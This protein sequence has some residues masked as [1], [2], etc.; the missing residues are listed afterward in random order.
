MNLTD[1]IDQHWR[2]NPLQKIAL[3]RLK[4]KTLRD[5]LFYLPSRYAQAGQFKKISELVAGETAMIYGQVLKTETKKAHFKKI[6]M[7]EAVIADESGK[8]SA[9]WFHQPYLAKKLTEGQYTQFAGKVSE[10]NGRL[11]LTNPQIGDESTIFDKDRSLFSN[12]SQNL[13][14]SL[15]PLVTIYPETKGLS[16]GWFQYHISQLLKNN[17]MEQIVDPLP[18]DI[19]SR[20][21]LPSL[22]T[23][24]V[25]IHQPQKEADATA[26]RKRFAFDEVFF[27]Q[28]SRLKNKLDYQSNPSYQLK[29]SAKD[30]NDFLKRFPF[31]P[32][33]AQQKAVKDILF[34]FEKNKPMTRLLEGDVGSGKTAVAAATAYA[35]V[36]AGFEVAYMAPTEI[37]AKQH[38]NSFIENFRGLG[39]QIGLLTGGECLK[40]PSK[41]NPNKATH[42]SKSQLLK[43]VAGGQIPILIGTHALIQK[44][45]KFR[46]LA[47]TIIDEQHRFGVMQRAKLVRRFDADKT[48]IKTD[49]KL[50]YKDLS[51]E[52]RG[53]IF[54]VANTLGLGH[55]EIIYQKSLEEEFKKKRIPFS[56]EKQIP[57]F[58]ADKKVGVY[59]PN[60]V[61]DDKIIVE[62]KAVPFLGLNE[63]KQVWN[64]L[65]GSSC[66]LALLVN[67]SPTKI[68]IER[69]IYDTAKFSSASYS[70]KSASLSAT[71][72]HLLSMTATPIPRTLALTIYGDLDL[73]ILDQLPVGRKAIITEII[74]PNKRD[75][76]YDHI[77]KELVAGRQAYVICPRIENA[78]LTPTNAGKISP[79]KNLELKSAKSEAVRLQKDIFPE[80]NIGLLHS[81]LNPKTKDQTMADFTAGKIDILVATS[82]VEVGVNVPNATIIIIEG[83][84]RFGLAQ[85]H[86]L[87]GRVMRSSHQAYCYI[88]SE[89]KS[90]NSLKRLQALKQAKSG[91]ELAEIDLAL[92]GAGLLSGEKQW[93]IS[94][95]GMEALR[96]LKMVEAARNEAERLITEDRELENHPEIASRLAKLKQEIHFE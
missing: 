6:P 56:K 41:I 48:P 93:G 24:L 79:P 94:D 46:N 65:R 62:L 4:L 17:L 80:F 71:V 44:K 88:F 58:Y 51:Y 31:K 49:E 96:N 5:L 26:A 2:I 73:S 47:Y 15:G 19:I 45:V 72:P 29:L 54:T 11:Y 40:F 8:I 64:Y 16:S 37:L 28:L 43:W 77:R 57:I 27:I 66:K 22:K 9:I 67:F 23:A 42:I 85:L 33:Y 91:F 14:S 38:F 30:L 87:R 12:D 10:R 39:V 76:A 82:V 75:D 81:K 83:A 74:P 90:S 89:T 20:Y 55:K 84:E 69:I 34:D 13:S 50:L 61:I 35:V 3:N 95:L 63:K 59:V 7:G 18:A 52:I 32:T 68:E 92:R 70:Q 60:F 1:P 21:H 78:D 36:K 53:V 86:Q 25:W